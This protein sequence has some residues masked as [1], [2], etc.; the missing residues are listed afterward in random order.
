[1]AGAIFALLV[2]I[3][4]CFLAEISHQII[5]WRGIVRI[6]ANLSIN[7]ILVIYSKSMAREEERREYEKYLNTNYNI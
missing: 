3:S 1:M 5:K 2:I 6:G 4:S 7:S